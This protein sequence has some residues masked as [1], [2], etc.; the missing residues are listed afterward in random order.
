MVSQLAQVVPWEISRSSS[1]RRTIS[2]PAGACGG[3]APLGRPRGARRYGRA[4]AEP[5]QRRRSFFGHDAPKR[6]TDS[7]S[8]RA[9]RTDGPRADLTTTRSRGDTLA[10]KRHRCEHTPRRQTGRRTDGTARTDEPR[11]RARLT[12]PNRSADPRQGDYATACGSCDRQPDAAASTAALSR[13][14]FGQLGRRRHL[15]GPSVSFCSSRSRISYPVIRKSQCH[16][17]R[18]A[19]A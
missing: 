7:R 2:S 4:P 9:V 11:G 3:G 6:V 14:R 18:F 5:T 1:S 16:F 13:S 17:N 8:D 12:I 19:M 10:A 15:P